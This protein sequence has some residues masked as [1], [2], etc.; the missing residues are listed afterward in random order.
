MARIL[1]TARSDGRGGFSPFATHGASHAGE[2]VYVGGKPRVVSSDGR[3]NIPAALMRE[4]GIMG[5]DG[6]YRVAVETGAR[7][8]MGEVALGLFIS[9]PPPG[10]S[11]GQSGDIIP[12]TFFTEHIIY[13]SETEE[14]YAPQRG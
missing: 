10:M 13:P 6:R 3:V 11:S 5:P 8:D 2:T 12:R 7:T 4:V 14:F 9:P 1:V